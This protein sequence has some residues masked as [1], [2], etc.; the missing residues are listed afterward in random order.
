[1]AAMD[2]QAFFMEREQVLMVK[3]KEL[4]EKMMQL[5]IVAR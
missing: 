5:I 1:M 2:C 3:A 4:S